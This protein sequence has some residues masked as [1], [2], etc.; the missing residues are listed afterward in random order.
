[1]WHAGMIPALGVRAASS[2]ML[3]TSRC[4]PPRQ[5]L[6]WAAPK[7]AILVL[8][9]TELTLLGTLLLPFQS[10]VPPQVEHRPNRRAQ[11]VDLDAA[12]DRQAIFGVR[13][14]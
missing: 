8:E 7:G 11:P 9:S 14:T 5:P 4:P 6:P 2:S 12:E 1:M 13:L 10:A 3:M